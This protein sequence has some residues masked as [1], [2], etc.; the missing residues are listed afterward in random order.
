M[1]NV[2][3]FACLAI[4]MN[5]FAIGKNI[6]GNGIL[7]SETREIG[8]FE[9][10]SSGG[11]MN[12]EITYGT[13]SSLII[14]G[15]ENI[16]PYIETYVK[17]GTLKIKV[18]DLNTV[19]PQLKLKVRINMTAID[20]ISQ[21]GSGMISGSGKFENND[22]TNFNMSGSGRI[23][24]TFAK[25]NGANISMSG[26]GSIELKGDINGDLD[27]H[28]SGSGN[29]NCLNAPCDNVSASMSGSGT[30]KINATKSINARISGSGEIYYTGTP[31]ISS[32]VSG[33]GH[34]RKV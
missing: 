11:P 23:E 27:L 29:I 32:H 26:S 22:A 31:S 18:K 12:V 15:D 14:E 21:S 6:K 20:A 9:S 10:L 34:I 1:K 30:L 24:L 7:K 19:S 13:S 3:L 33:S 16:L 8:S 5:S 28:Q 4:T 2:L 25:F 17:D